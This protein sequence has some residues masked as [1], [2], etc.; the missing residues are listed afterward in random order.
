MRKVA[1]E[2]SFRTDVG[3][4]ALNILFNTNKEKPVITN[5][6]IPKN[7]NQTDVLLSNAKGNYRSQMHTDNNSDVTLSVPKVLKGLQYLRRSNNDKSFFTILDKMSTSDIKWVDKYNNESKVDPNMSLPPELYNELSFMLYKKSLSLSIYDDPEKVFTL[8][9]YALK[10]LKVYPMTRDVHINIKCI[11]RCLQMVTKTRSVSY[12]S[13]ALEL[14]E[15]FDAKISD[16]LKDTLKDIT[17]LDLFNQTKQYPKLLNKIDN[18]S[19]QRSFVKTVNLYNTIFKSTLIT[20]LKGIMVEGYTSQSVKLLKQLTS[21]DNILTTH[22]VNVLL[23]L[24]ERLD[25]QEIKTILKKLQGVQLPEGADFHLDE[26]AALP[27]DYI[28]SILAIHKD[29]LLIYG[30]KHYDSIMATLYFKQLTKKESMQVLEESME[31]F[32]DNK[33]KR[34]IIIDVILSYISKFETVDNYISITNYLVKDLNAT[35]DLLNSTTLTK[36]R[37]P[38]LYSIFNSIAQ[39]SENILTSMV[40]LQRFAGMKN[41]NAPLRLEDCVL[42]LEMLNDSLQPELLK[43]KLKGFILH[44][45]FI[46]HVKSFIVNGQFI[47]PQNLL[48]ILD[49]TT[50]PEELNSIISEVQKILVDKDLSTLENGVLQNIRAILKEKYEDIDI[51]SIEETL[52][53]LNVDKF[54]PVYYNLTRDKYIAGQV[55]QLFDFVKL[56]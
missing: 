55:S 21:S 45:I 30:T 33:M 32:K 50:P 13:L 47:I 2:K 24:V 9:R 5:L 39:S 1:F 18:C 56:T 12:V 20:I 44:H 15:T 48:D 27:I 28:A 42:V 16:D 17:I 36:S 54:L 49:K 10:L 22:D 53:T 37:F 31:R 6:N 26:L 43:S 29:P 3:E 7:K 11:N 14:V 51:I 41:V 25:N 23:P 4:I 46:E 52:S 38:G 34:A 35:A 8:A 19:N 40:V